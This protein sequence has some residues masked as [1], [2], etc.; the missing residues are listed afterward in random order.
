MTLH[1]TRDGQKITVHGNVNTEVL[2]KD[3]HVQHVRITEDAQHVRFFHDQLGKLLF[4]AEE[5]RAAAAEP[6]HH[7]PG[8]H[9]HAAPLSDPGLQHHAATTTVTGTSRIEPHGQG[10]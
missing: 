9:S 5:E 1:A 8:A 6:E 2:V 3:G 4:A 10:Y 7:H